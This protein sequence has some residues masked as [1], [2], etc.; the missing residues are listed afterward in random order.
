MDVYSA[1]YHLQSMTEI[2][3]TFE[4]ITDWSENIKFICANFWK[5]VESEHFMS[6]FTLMAYVTCV[7]LAI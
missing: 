3:V 5:Q 2:R 6:E 1:H 7:Y 4:N